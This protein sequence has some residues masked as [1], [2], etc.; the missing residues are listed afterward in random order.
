MAES[1]ADKP[2]LNDTYTD[3][4]SITWPVFVDGSDVTA[5]DVE[6]TLSSKYGDEYTLQPVNAY[7]E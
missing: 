5:Q 1:A 4:F 7:G 6:I 2:Y 3:C